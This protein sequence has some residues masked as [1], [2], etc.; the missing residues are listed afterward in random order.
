MPG[1]S[2]ED[3]DRLA[4][5]VLRQRLR[6]RPKENV[7]IETYPSS[8]PWATGFVREARRLGAKPILLYEDERSYWTAVEE[9]RASLLGTP[10]EHEWAA[11]GDSD[12]YV[13]FWGPETLARRR[14]VTEAEAEKLTAFNLAWYQAARK[15]GLRGARMGIARVT[16][17]NARLF[18]V[19]FGRW[20]EQVFR[21]SLR[22]PA[23]LRASARS[24]GRRLERGRSV[25][26]RH[27]NG[28]DLTLALAGR[29]AN[30][31]VGDVTP[32]MMKTA[33][34]RMANVPDGTVY[35][36]V[37]ETTA[38]GTFVANRPTTSVGE[39]PLEGG[40]FTFRDGRLVRSAF[41]RGG[42][43]FRTSYRT[44]RPGKERPSFLEIGL[45][46]DLGGAPMFE[47]SERG[48]LTV[49]VGRNVGFGGKTDTNFLGYLT[50]TGAELTLDGRA[51]VRRGRLVGA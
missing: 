10:G 44:A 27:S 19:P 18:G 22:D 41:R 47:E 1:P 17:A 8:L 45:D 43:S 13:Y 50:L 12:V 33:F 4:R 51:V 29:K 35:V 20:R 37:D 32:E 31:T 26:I 3:A 34:G 6:V 49:G 38:E 30:L 25:R 48:A 46:P 21:A 40:R 7:T 28:T 36:A 39:P 9:G 15:A 16:P 42:G 14:A 23:A 5:G 24:L 2:V 11:L